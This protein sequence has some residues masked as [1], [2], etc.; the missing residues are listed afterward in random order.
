MVMEAQE[1][2]ARE[3]IQLEDVAV[4]PLCGLQERSALYE[5]LEDRW[6]DVPGKW[7]LSRCKGCGLTFLDPRPTTED[8]GKTYSSYYTHQIPLTG[9]SPISN[10]RVKSWPVALL[11][12]IHR[13]IYAP[14][15]R[16]QNELF[17]MHLSRLTPGRLLDVGCGDGRFLKHMRDLGWTVQGVETD[18]QSA[19]LAVEAFGLSVHLGTLESARF[20][21][22]HFDSV[23]MSHVIEHAH[24]PIALLAECRRILRPGGTLV[25]VTPNIQSMGH[26][27]FGKAWR[28]LDPPRHLYLFSRKTLGMIVSQAG[29]VHPETHTSAARADMISIG[30]MQIKETGRYDETQ[31]FNRRWGLFSLLFSLLELSVVRFMRNI[32][33]ELV[34]KVRK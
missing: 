10:Q 32:G 12:K 15:V 16:K 7:N 28:D 19:K 24:D 27:Y 20:L 9:Q 3:P 11:K 25:I 33:E 21:S 29:F 2:M 30:S 34:L 5:G 26:R 22:D 18:P 6:F 8:T 23:T 17:E 13:W 4:C 14:L 31:L 1:R